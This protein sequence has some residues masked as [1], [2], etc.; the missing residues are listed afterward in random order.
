[1]TTEPVQFTEADPAD[2]EAVELIAALDRDLKQRYHGMPV[3]GIQAEGFVRSGGVLV[4]RIA[5]T[6]A[7]CGAVRPLD[8]VTAE[9]KRM[10]VRPEYRGRGLAGA[11]LA[12]LEEVARVRGYRTIRL[13]TGDGQPEAI[14]LYRSAGYR[15]IDCFGEYA[16]D[17][18]CLCFEKTLS[19]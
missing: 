1:M 13:E 16:A 15:P 3:R 9:L 19:A 18:T 5:G 11:L 14:A 7:G 2:R 8:N 12:A 6:A 4:A 10:F 17:P